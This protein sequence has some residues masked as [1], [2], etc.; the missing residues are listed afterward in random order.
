[1]ELFNQFIK[2]LVI[3]I[4]FLVVILCAICRYKLF[5]SCNGLMVKSASSIDRDIR[6]FFEFNNL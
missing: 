6:A 3:S 2:A 1:M 5:I 4:G